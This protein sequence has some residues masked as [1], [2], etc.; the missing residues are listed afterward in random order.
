MNEEILRMTGIGKSFGPVKA[1]HD[2]HLELRSGEVMA[3]LGENGAGKSTLMK[4]LTGVYSLDEGSITYFGKDVNYKTPKEAQEAGIAIVH[5]ELSMMQD[6]T[7]AQNIYLGRENMK[8]VLI[9]DRAMNREAKKIFDALNVNVNPASIVR[10]IPVGMQQMS[11]IARAISEDAKIIIFDEPTTSLTDDEIEQLFVI[12][13][14]LKSQGIG[15]IYISHRM[16]E[17]GRITDRITVLRD[18]G[19]VGTV[20]TKDTTREDLIKMMVGRVVYVEPKQQSLVPPDA[21]VILDVRNLNSGEHVK[22]VSFTLRRGEVLGFAGLMGAGRTETARA[23]FGAD[24][25][26]SGEIHING[27]KVN[28][29]TTADAVAHG[30]G[31]LSEDRR[32]D[33]MITGF[34]IQDNIAIVSIDTFLK[35]LLIDDGKIKKTASDF[36]GALDIKCSSTE[37]I[38]KT[39]SGGNQ[40]KVVIAKWLLRDSDILIFDEPTK[41]IDVGAKSEI[42][43]IIQKLANAGKGIIMISSELEEI[44]RMSDRI[45]VMAE[46]RK[47]AE[48]D[49]AEATQEK[50]MTYASQEEV[51]A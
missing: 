9:N 36:V 12:I 37:Q 28:I 29:R 21:P 16:D 47:T 42:Y 20:N 44:L 39:L 8:G 7:V 50:I 6:L 38:A 25:I 1:L 40:Q 33:G 43:S 18:G 13:R 34:T 10:D 5:Q 35:G 15:I 22:D 11:E 27:E 31:Y 23:I 24:P 45:L 26:D 51:S 46:G 48:L 2:V 3:L 4:I 19:F 41:G 30:I 32:V 17:I 49:I 14:Q